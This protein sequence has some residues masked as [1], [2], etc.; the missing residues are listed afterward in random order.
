MASTRQTLPG[1][2]GSIYRLCGL[3]TLRKSC[4]RNVCRG[5]IAGDQRNHSSRYRNPERLYGVDAFPTPTRLNRFP[6]RSMIHRKQR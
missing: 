3:R 1:R 6:G 5:G 4:G 2:C